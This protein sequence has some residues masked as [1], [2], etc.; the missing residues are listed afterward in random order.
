MGPCVE[1][2]SVLS[3]CTHCQQSN[4]AGMRQS[5]EGRRLQHGS[6]LAVSFSLVISL[7]CLCT[8]VVAGAAP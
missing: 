4:A 3:T 8:P 1:R 5:L 6:S 2:V 7:P